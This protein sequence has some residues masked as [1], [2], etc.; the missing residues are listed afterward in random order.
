MLV[1]V[2]TRIQRARDPWKI[3]VL[4]LFRLALLGWFATETLRG[5]FGGGATTPSISVVLTVAWLAVET[6]TVLRLRAAPG[7][8]A[9]ARG[10]HRDYL[11]QL[12]FAFEEEPPAPP[13]QIRWSLYVAVGLLVAT[14]GLA[15]LLASLPVLDHRSSPW[16]LV[17]Y[18]VVCSASILLS[19]TALA[20][21]L[22]GWKREHGF[23][24][25]LEIFLL[26]LLATGGLA[27]W[28]IGFVRVMFFGA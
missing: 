25:R 10:R 4:F 11:D 23:R 24:G 17:A 1:H 13:R 26:A 27:G 8:L 22:R 3:W 2:A 12:G 19:A 14:I 9:A 5:L 20:L 16:R 18:G 21:A 28:T 15:A 6:R 7:R